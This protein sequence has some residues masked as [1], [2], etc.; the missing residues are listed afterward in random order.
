MIQVSMAFLLTFLLVGHGFAQSD[1]DNLGERAIAARGSTDYEAIRQAHTYHITR[2]TGKIVIDGNIDEEAWQ[3]AEASDAF[4]QQEPYIGTAPTERTE[5]RLLYDDTNLY[6]SFI[7][8]QKWPIVVNELRR[9]YSP[10]DTDSVNIVFDTFDDD[11]NG[12]L[13]QMNPGSALRDMQIVGGSFSADWNG[14][15]D[16]RAKV[17]PPGWT[18][19]MAIPLKTLRFN[20]DPSQRWGLNALRITRHTNE[21]V[22]WSLGPRPFQLFDVAIAGSL[23]GL[24]NIQQGSNLNIKP[25]MVTNYRPDAT[26]GFL[27]KHDTDVGLDVKYGVTSEL[28]LDLTVN[29]DF[30]QVEADEQQVNL[31]RFSLFFP[32]KREFFLENAG[33]FQIGGQAGSGPR[34]GGAAREG[35]GGRGNRGEGRRDII[36]FFSRRIGL[37]NAQPLPIRG[38]A[39][40]TGKLGPFQIGMLNMQVGSQGDIPSANWTAL[41]VKQE[42]LSNSDY[43]G[44]FFNRSSDAD[45][46]NRAG[47]V[48][49]TF[50]FLRRRLVFSGFAMNTFTPLEDKKNLAAEIQG[51]YTDPLFHFRSSFVTVEDEFRND[52]GFVPR[53]SIRKTRVAGSIRPRP[54]SGPVR[55]IGPNFET[56]YVTDQQGQLLTRTHRAVI[57]V[58]THSGDSAHFDREMNFER[59]YEPFEIR[60]GVLLPPGDH[61]FDDWNMGVATSRGRKFYGSLGHKTGEFWTGTIRENR[62][63]VGFRPSPHFRTELSWIRNHVQLPE[64]DFETDLVRLRLNMHF[65]P[66]VLLENFIQ[67]NTDAQ[68]VAYNVRFR[69]IHHPLSD[70]FVVYNE[71]RGIRGNDELSRAV[72]I[73]LTNLFVF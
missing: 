54:R 22:M 67:Y 73:K 52:F 6:V 21:W 18:A 55:D 3:A 46:W 45:N 34:G 28:T 20:A 56:N 38:G 49:G 16:G 14:V 37:H 23:E 63:V 62:S 53:G 47:G 5:M 42:V 29:T 66:R 1:P 51:S 44:F 19:E 71:T 39:R 57:E 26:A 68:T 13:F 10:A 31:T 32:E 2:T 24:E 25:F 17:Q 60:D 72:S 61:A 50:R 41:R 33:I 27:K 65:S 58:R 40:L 48:D 69:F 8:H 11:R 36:P 4:L 70:F 64:G 7:C 12:F 15:F 9:D 35:G 30:S 59:L 43:G